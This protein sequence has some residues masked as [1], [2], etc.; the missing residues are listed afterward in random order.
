MVLTNSLAPGLMYSSGAD[1]LV[2]AH[3]ELY[4]A[5][6]APVLFKA[7]FTSCP[8][9]SHDDSKMVVPGDRW[10]SSLPP[11]SRFAWLLCSSGLPCSC[12]PVNGEQRQYLAPC[13]KSD[14]G[15]ASTMPPRWQ[16]AAFLH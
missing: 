16:T 4:C 15:R 10:R 9:G 7:S 12:S 5:V 1:K 13:N 6:I 2:I 8:S 3:T 11:F 14:L